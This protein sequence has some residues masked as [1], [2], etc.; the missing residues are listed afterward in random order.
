METHDWPLLV[1]RAVSERSEKELLMLFN[2]RS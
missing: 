2:L 1:G